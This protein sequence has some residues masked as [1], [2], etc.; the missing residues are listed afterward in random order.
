MYHFRSEPIVN[1][2]LTTPEPV[3][4]EI[5]ETGTNKHSGAYMASII[6]RIVCEIG[7]KKV[8]SVVSDNAKNMVK[9]WDIFIKN[10][11][12][13]QISFFG[14]AGH[15][16]NLLCKDIV[17][18]PTFREIQN[19]TK[20]IIKQFK[21]SHI[22]NGLLKEIQSVGI[23]TEDVQNSHNITLK[24][25]VVTRWGSEAASLKS[26]IIN[27]QYLKQVAI[28]N[29]SINLLSK[30]SVT[31]ILDNTTF[32]VQVETM[33]NLLKPVANWISILESETCNVST[34]VVAFN[35]IQEVFAK[36]IQSSTLLK[37]EEYSLLQKLDNRK[38]MAV[39][40][41]HLAGH[42]LDPIYK[43]KFLKNNESIDATEFISNLAEHLQISIPDIMSEL[44]E[45][46]TNSGLW[47]KTFVWDSLKAR[48]DETRLHPLTWWKGICTSAKISSIAVAILECS[49]T[50]ASTERSFSTYG[51]VHTARRNRLTNDRAS[52]LVYIKHNLKIE[53]GFKQNK[54]KI[55]LLN[56]TTGEDSY[57]FPDAVE[58]EEEEDSIV[59]PSDNETDEL[60]N[61]VNSYN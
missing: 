8:I 50:S 2:V 54:N 43:G 36:Q 42:L 61:A 18:L 47:S 59:Y 48:S 17:N 9:A 14:C 16:L 56:N 13:S 5:I 51:I 35:E 27:K 41:I 53:Q 38:H 19:S 10:N 37:K 1:I 49:P 45:Y 30:E 39:R 4:Y 11:P 15:V 58:E 29:K 33:Y 25:P 40:K 7:P 55:D 32:W 44:A 20:N 22:L 12:S 28:S 57:D 21:Y 6:E 23:S 31:S 26:L 46:R 3:V 34:V 24:L 52:K 60:F